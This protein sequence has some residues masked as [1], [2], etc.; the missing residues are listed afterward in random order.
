MI[1]KK[2]IVSIILMTMVGYT[3]NAQ[4]QRT[5]A[6]KQTDSVVAKQ[7]TEKN[8]DSR[9]EMLKELDLTKDQKNKMKEINGS[10]KASKEAIENDTALSTEEKKVKLKSLRQEQMQK[11]QALLTEEQKAKFRKMKAKKMLNDD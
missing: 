6:K 3:S 10:T 11:I 4:V 8:P 9:K 7:V 5:P 2:Y 1:M